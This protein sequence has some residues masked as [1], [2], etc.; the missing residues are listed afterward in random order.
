MKFLDCLVVFFVSL[1]IVLAVGGGL[2]VV[3]M[4]P[5]SYQQLIDQ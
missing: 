2:E 3:E 4:V 5:Q 1:N